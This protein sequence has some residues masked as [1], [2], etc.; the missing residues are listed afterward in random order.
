[1]DNLVLT[2][3]IRWLS[4]RDAFS[5]CCVSREWNA[6]LSPEE[7]E[8]NLWRQVCHNTNPL[9]TPDM[10]QNTNFRRLALGLMDSR[11]RRVPPRQ[12]FIPTLSPEDIF[13]VVELHKQKEVNGKRRKV[14]EASWKSELSFP[15]GLV[16][17]D[18]QVILKGANPYSSLNR[19]SAHTRKWQQELCTTGLEYLHYNDTMPQNYAMF[20]VFGEFYW[21][22]SLIERKNGALGLRV[23]LFRR[24]NM[25]SICILDETGVGD[26]YDD[27]DGNSEVIPVLYRNNSVVL[28]FDSTHEGNKGNV[29]M[30]QEYHGAE[31]GSCGRLAIKPILPDPGSDEEPTWLA[32]ARRVV[33][34]RAYCPDSADEAILLK[35]PHFDA[36]VVRF[37]VRLSA[38]TADFRTQ[39]HMMVALEGLCWR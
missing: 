23:T 39:D 7:D 17:P 25:K 26:M 27:E 21:N 35:I 5:V 4:A 20:D 18:K 12:S 32:N 3:A 30:H 11:A 38:G 8:S 6:A 37:S 9:V 19:D 16:E 10:E 2:L 15:H 24:D 1:M 14:L 33:E 28:S 29:L 13:A 34:E 36:E 31:F 22:R